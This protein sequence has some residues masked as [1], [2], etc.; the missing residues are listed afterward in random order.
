MPQPKKSRFDAGT[1]L[2]LALA[3]GGCARNY[4]SSIEPRYAGSHMALRSPLPASDTLRVVSFNVQFAREIRKATDLLRDSPSLR[5]ADILLLQE[6][7]ARGTARI[8]HELG[9][10]WVYYPA[11]RHPQTGRDF[12][13][14]VLSRLPIESDQKVILPHLA[15]LGRTQ[16]V[17]VAA[18]VR[19]GGELLRVY[20]LHLATFTGNGPKARRQQFEAVLADADSFSNVLIAGDFNSESIPGIAS[21]H[22]Y[23]W[24]TR[25]LPPTNVAGTI[26]HIVV[27]GLELADRRSAGVV[28]R[29]G[30]TSDH[31]P[32][33]AQ[34]V[35]DPNTA[36]LGTGTR[37]R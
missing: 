8:A 26:D 11:T 35:R 5:G 32:I 16:R 34:L 33:W 13:N 10:H 19:W 31:K 4:T 25:D 22:G 18:T 36:M 12:G 37:G 6:M 7:D 3:G 23:S 2:L 29:V 27:R 14:A 28:P 15:R 17:A 1:L 20:S 9:Y 30:G 21:G 24:P